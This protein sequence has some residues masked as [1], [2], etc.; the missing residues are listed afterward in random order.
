MMKV[1]CYVVAYEAAPFIEGVLKAIPAACRRDARFAFDVMVSDDCSGDGTLEACERFNATAAHP[2]VVTRTPYNLGYG[3]NQ[4][5]GYDY[6]L[7]RGY[8]AVVLLH[9]DG[10]Y[11]PAAIPRLLDPIVNRQADVV[12]GSR[13]LHKR[14]ALKG[15]MP[16]YKFLGNILLTWFQNGAL[17]TQLS[18]FHTGLRAYGCKALRVIPYGANNDGYV[19]DT[20]ILIQHIAARHRIA[21]IP[22]ATHYGKEICHVNGPRYAWNVV[23][24]TLAYRLHRL[25]FAHRPAYDIGEGYAS[26]TGFDSSHRFA[27]EQAAG[28]TRVLDI[29]GGAGHVAAAL[30][31]QGLF[32]G[33][34]DVLSPEKAGRR[35]DVYRRQDIEREFSV[36][37]LG[38]APDAVLL[39]DVLEHLREPERLLRLLRGA[40]EAG[41]RVVITVPNVA[42]LSVRLKLLLGIF[43]YGARGIMDHS[44]LRFFTFRSLQAMLRKQGYAIVL[45]RGIPAPFPLLVRAPWL[46]GALLRLNRVLIVLW[47]GLFSF[48]IGLVATP[49]RIAYDS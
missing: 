2:A 30:R 20:E 42:F 24:A 18:E 17:G 22:I 12:L 38:F 37:G 49:K 27:I 5:R 25:G 15:G 28:A 19:F 7:A 43:S 31:R 8:D 32:V 35:Y 26:K 3:G 44:H 11:D 34:V 36:A 13:M 46:A 39:L 1:L 16:W 14:D 29:G 23:C 41:S 4:K 45:R 9:G 33:G 48:Q 6:A 10:Q 47:P 21:E 40:V